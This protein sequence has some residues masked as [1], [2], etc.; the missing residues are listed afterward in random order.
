LTFAAAALYGPA[1]IGRVELPAGSA[2]HLTPPARMECRADLR[3]RFE[4]G[5]TDER[6]GE[7]FCRTQHIIRVSAA[8]R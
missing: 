8:P 2:L 5:R 1:L 4:D 6:A 3:I 7:D